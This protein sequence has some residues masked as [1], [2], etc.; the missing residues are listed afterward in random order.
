MQEEIE[1]QTHPATLDRQ[2]GKLQHCPEAA[3]LTPCSK[4]VTVRGQ[5]ED[6]A[7]MWW[8]LNL[9]YFIETTLYTFKALP[10]LQLSSKPPSEVKQLVLPLL[11]PA[12]E[13]KK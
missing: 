4:Q 6:M 5:E 12:T 1:K 10:S 7:A 2:S 13:N 11:T 8:Y 9:F 3:A